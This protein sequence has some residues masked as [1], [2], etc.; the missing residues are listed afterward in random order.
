MM[1]IGHWLKT[2]Q[3][4]LQKKGIATARLDCLVLLEDTLGINR[5]RLLAEPDTQLSP[6]QQAKLKNLLNRRAS[7][8]PLAYIR[9]HSEFYGRDFV[10]TPDVLE[11]RPES[12]AIIDL[13]KGL[14][15]SE[16]QWQE[17]GSK[18]L[19]ADVGTGSGAL[20]ITAALEVPN[21]TVDLLEI[22]DEAAKIAK[23]NVDK[24]TISVSVIISDL[25]A[26]APVAYDV[27]LCNLPY[28]PDE[29]PINDAAGFEPKIAL[30]GGKDGLD[31][32][33]RLFDQIGNLQEQP[34]YLLIESLP[35]Q[36]GELDKIA[37]QTG[38]KLQMTKDFIQLFK[39]SN[40][41]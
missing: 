5:A 16:P 15:S 23:I 19:V 8:E 33:K 10:I 3:Q 25:L 6:D 12:E 30:F 40:N 26:N 13:F 37:A 38:Y 4:D 21:C 34:L 27:L 41:V 36:H 11:P 14:A 7:H 24:F 29:Y 1:K 28:V 2:A 20:G 32:Y 35:A 39:R 31:L 17:V 22:S 18:V 9:E